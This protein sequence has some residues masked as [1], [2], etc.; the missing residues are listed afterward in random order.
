M[1]LKVTGERDGRHGHLARDSSVPCLFP[2]P[3]LFPVPCLFPVPYLFPV[4]CLFP[5]P[6]LFPVPCLFPVPYFFPVPCLFFVPCLSPLRYSPTLS[7][8]PP[9]S[10]TNISKRPPVDARAIIASIYQTFGSITILGTPIKPAFSLAAGLSRAGRPE[11]TTP[12]EGTH[13]RK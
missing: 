5:V 2:V 10:S 11:S 6:Y 9:P 12:A 1:G 3:Y 7:P 4:P 13:S 8:P